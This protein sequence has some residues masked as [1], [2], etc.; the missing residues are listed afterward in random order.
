MNCHIESLS[1]KDLRHAIED[2]MINFGFS[3]F[4]FYKR[5]G[6]TGKINKILSIGG[7]L[8]GSNSTGGNGVY[9]LGRES[10][11]K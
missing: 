9:G 8:T 7:T 3:L 4:F 11:R 6:L 2:R 1:M 5:L 10:L